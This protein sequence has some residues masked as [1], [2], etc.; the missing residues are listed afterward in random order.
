MSRQYRSRPWSLPYKAFAAQQGRQKA[1]MQLL[2]PWLWVMLAFRIPCLYS[3]AL[4]VGLSRCLMQFQC[5]M[6]IFMLIHA[7][8]RVPLLQWLTVGRQDAPNAKQCILCRRCCQ[9]KLWQLSAGILASTDK[10]P[11]GAHE[12]KRGKGKSFPPSARCPRLSCPH[13]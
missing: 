13:W 6:Y 3:R 9:P 4:T 1:T 5:R 7:L 12:S 10:S 8:W 11:G 2:L